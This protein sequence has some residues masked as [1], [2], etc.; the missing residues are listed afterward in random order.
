ML[1]RAR[2]ILPVCRP[3]IEDGA[4]SISGQR[5]RFVGPWKDVSRTSQRRAIDLGDVILMPGLINAHCHLDYTHMAGEF[6]PPRVFTDWLKLI[7]T[8]KSLWSLSDYQTSW[9]DGAQMLVRN[10]VTTV[11]DIEAM[12]ELL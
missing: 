1:L 10:G 11:A 3:P 8:A 4:I 7:T 5:I 6:A 2:T 9:R 12:P